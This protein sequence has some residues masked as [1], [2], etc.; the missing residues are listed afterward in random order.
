M[1]MIA[2]SRPLSP[3]ETFRDKLNYFEAR[4][5]VTLECGT[6]SLSSSGRLSLLARWID[7]PT[8]NPRDNVVKAQSNRD[9]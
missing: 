3:Q 7:T 2:P 6:A 9:R 8:L 5:S 4:K 1:F